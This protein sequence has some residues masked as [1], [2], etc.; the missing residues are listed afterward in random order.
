MPNVDLQGAAA[1]FKILVSRA[2]ELKAELQG[3]AAAQSISVAQEHA[4][5]ALASQAVRGESLLA[6]GS[7]KKRDERIAALTHQ[8]QGLSFALSLGADAAATAEVESKIAELTAERA[9][10][11]LVAVG[12]YSELIDPTTVRALVQLAVQVHDAAE[13]KQTA[14]RIIGLV[15]QVIGAATTVAGAVATVV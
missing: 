14:S 7:S 11:F 4:L 5:Q 12:D 8:I 3:N 13:R 6:S 10:L 1:A 9:Q 2:R 15:E